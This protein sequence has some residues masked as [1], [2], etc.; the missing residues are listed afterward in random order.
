[1]NTATRV[2]H[3]STFEASRKWVFTLHRATMMWVML[4]I[5]TLA[6]AFTVIYL[7]DLNRR[8]F[9]RYQSLQQVSQQYALDWSKLLLEQSTLARQSRIQRIAQQQLGMQWPKENRIIV[10]RE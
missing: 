5:L 3:A 7:K 6:S 9:I 8:L 4:V 2:T 1:M 10:V